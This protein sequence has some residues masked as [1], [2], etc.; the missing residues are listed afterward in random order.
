MI[1]GV[2]NDVKFLINKITEADVSPYRVL[3]KLEGSQG[4]FLAGA[5]GPLGV[6]VSYCKGLE[7]NPNL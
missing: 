4:L 7:P 6:L 5:Q 3:P 1:C 2:I